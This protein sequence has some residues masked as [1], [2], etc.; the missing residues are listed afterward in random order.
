MARDRKI[1]LPNGSSS[2]RLSDLA[3]REDGQSLVEMA[4]SLL[5]TVGLSLFVFEFSLLAYTY[6]VM[7]NA[8]REGVRYAIVHGTNNTACS[9]PGGIGPNATT[10]T[11]GDSTGANVVSKVTTYAAASLHTLPSADVAVNYLDSS[12]AAPARV[13]VMVTYPYVPFINYPGTAPTMTL[14][15]QGR[16]V[17]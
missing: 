2:T 11:C 15:A 4:L 8:A 14:I 5:L 9:G 17:N 6:A 1:I 10:V 7:N 16:I 12:S 3:L 13:Q